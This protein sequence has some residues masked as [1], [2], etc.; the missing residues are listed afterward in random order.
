[1]IYR[2]REWCNYSLH[3]QPKCVE[4]EGKSWLSMGWHVIRLLGLDLL[5]PPRSEGK[6]I[7][8]TRSLI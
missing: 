4:L 8:G 5:S 6:D 1:M 3:A 7:R 2:Y